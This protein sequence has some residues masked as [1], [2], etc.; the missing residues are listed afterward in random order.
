ME[1][2]NLQQIVN[3]YS[4]T[5]AAQLMRQSPVKTGALKRSIKVKGKQT[6]KGL[7]FTTD[8]KRYGIFTDLG[9]GPYA[10]KKRGEW[11]PKPGKGRGGIRPRFWTTLPEA[12]RKNMNK[13]IG[14]LMKE[15][16][17]FMLIRKK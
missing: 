7:T 13:S 5:I 6:D 16:I 10:T 14:K 8:Y 3:Y 15:Y 12:I 1:D 9:T 4:R 2:I 11:N 17:R